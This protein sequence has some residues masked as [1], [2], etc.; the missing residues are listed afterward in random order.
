MLV[1]SKQK[2]A[3]KNN[4]GIVRS[5]DSMQEAQVHLMSLKVQPIYENAQIV[6]V[7]NANHE[8]LLG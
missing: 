5:F 2:Y 1:D 6:I 8:L 3:I 7:D 4:G